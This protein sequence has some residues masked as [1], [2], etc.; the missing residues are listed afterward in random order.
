ML[1]RQEDKE[2]RRISKK[3]NLDPMI[4]DESDEEEDYHSPLTD[5]TKSS[6]TSLEEQ[7]SRSG[8]PD[9]RSVAGDTEATSIPAAQENTE[10]GVFAPTSVGS[11]LRRNM[12]GSIAVPKIL[13][14]RN[15]GSK[16]KN[17]STT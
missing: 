2:V 11:A 13:P 7:A 16:V 3:A 12:D 5:L 14:K 6:R 8:T 10:S 15:K 17:P 1:N 9:L 4:D